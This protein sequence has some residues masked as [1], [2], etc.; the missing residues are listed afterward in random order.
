MH[1]NEIFYFYGQIINAMRV[2]SFHTSAAS[3]S[4][5]LVIHILVPLRIQLS[6]SFLAVVN[7][8]PASLPLPGI[9]MKHKHCQCQ[10]RHRPI[11]KLDSSQ[12]HLLMAGL[13]STRR[14]QSKMAASK[15]IQSHHSLKKCTDSWLSLWHGTNVPL[16]LY[17]ISSYACCSINKKWHITTCIIRYSQ[18]CGFLCT[19]LHNK[20]ALNNTVRD[21]ASFVQH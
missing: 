18:R 2:T 6:P 7:A 12:S 9:N 13:D 8:A 11:M 16:Y 3:A 17:A 14:I 15:S 21:V 19:T 4:Y 20:A 5:P 1:W 10:V